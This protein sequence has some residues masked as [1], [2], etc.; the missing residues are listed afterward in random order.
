MA[1]AGGKRARQ[2]G[3]E[4]EREGEPV[5]PICFFWQP[6]TTA[7]NY[8]Q[9]FDPIKAKLLILFSTNPV[10]MLCAL[11]QPVTRPLRSKHGRRSAWPLEAKAPLSRS[12]EEKEE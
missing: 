8:S 10:R 2:K 12:Q 7:L 6:D 11:T 9:V 3:A 4:E 1:V 5:I